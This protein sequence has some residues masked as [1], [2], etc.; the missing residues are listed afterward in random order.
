MR[1]ADHLPRPLARIA[2]ALAFLIILYATLNPFDFHFV[3]LTVRAYLAGFVL[4]PSSPFDFPRNVLLFMPFGFALAALLSAAGW[5]NRRVWLAAGVG[6][7]FLTWLVESLQLFLPP[8]VSSVSDLASN[9]LGALAG[10]GLYRLWQ[11]RTAVITLLRRLLDSARAVAILLATYSLLLLLIAWLLGSTTGF[12][13]WS[14][15][16]PLLIGGEIN[17]GRSWRGEVRDVA[18]FDRA[19]TEADTLHLLSG[20]DPSGVNSGILLADYPLSGAAPLADRTGRQPDLAW[21]AWPGAST[22]TQEL[23]GKHWLRS[24]TAVSDL[25]RT[26]RDTSQVTI[27][28]TAASAAA[29]QDGPARIVSISGG[30][31]QRNLTVA[32]EGSNLALRLNTAVGGANGIGL[33]M[34]FLGQFAEQAPVTIVLRYDGLRASLHT[35]ATTPQMLELLPGPAFAHHLRPNKSARWIVNA[36]AL[37]NWL[38]HMLYYWLFYLPLG[39][40]LGAAT[41]RTWSRALR[42]GLWVWCLAALPLLAEGAL[43]FHVQQSPRPPHLLAAQGCIILGALIFR[44]WKHAASKRNA[45]R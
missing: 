29:D 18:I 10:A 8:R 16:F 7:F 41:A 30:T 11:E 14:T 15:A 44:R 27:L 23:D 4:P 2:L 35:S 33:E 22:S 42:T 25:S 38:L 31:Q 37:A 13:A 39:V 6:G 24:N 17:G 43:L 20:G 36:D 5:A 19:L 26:L 45:G 3:P 32:Q 12:G 9:T 1:G 21:H 34:H 40:F 28:F